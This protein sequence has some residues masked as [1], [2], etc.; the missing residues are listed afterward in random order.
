MRLFLLTGRGIA[1]VPAVEVVGAADGAVGADVADLPLDFN[2][3]VG[4]FGGAGGAAMGLFATGAR[5]LSF[6]RLKGCKEYAD[7]PRWLA[8]PR[9]IG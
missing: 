3:G 5:S 9:Q 1:A 8:Q 7:G 4:P 2:V 6:H